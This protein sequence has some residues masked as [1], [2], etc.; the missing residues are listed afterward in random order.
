LDSLRKHNVDALRLGVVAR[1]REDL[2]DHTLDSKVDRHPEKSKLDKLRQKADRERR[3]KGREARRRRYGYGFDDDDGELDP[4]GECNVCLLASSSC[5]HMTATSTEQ[6]IASLLKKMIKDEIE[7]AR[8]ICT[9]CVGAG[10]D[11]LRV[12]V[13]LKLA[14][15]FINASCLECSI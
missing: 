9:T 6:E 10:T 14:L 8:V 1:V 7:C 13:Q 2:V 3:K 11:R 12:N 15:L 4:D 5:F